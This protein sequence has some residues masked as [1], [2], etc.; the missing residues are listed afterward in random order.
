MLNSSIRAKYFLASIS[1]IFFSQFAFGQNCQI[2]VDWN[3]APPLPPGGSY[4]AG[5]VITI[6]AEI[7]DYTSG[8]ANWI[9]G[10]TINLSDAWD[11]SSITNLDLP[12]SCSGNGGE[13]LYFETLTCGG[14]VIDDPGFYYDSGVSG[15]FDGNPC[16]NW[17]DGAT[18]CAGWSFCLDI[19]LD[20][21]CGGPGNPFDGTDV[22]PTITVYSDSEVGSWNGATGCNFQPEDPP[23]FPVNLDCCDAEAGTP[24]AGPIN[25]CGNTPVDLFPLLVG[26][27]LGGTWT[28]PAGWSAPPPGD[29]NASFSPDTNPALSD[30]PGDY[31]YS[32]I[33]SDGCV[34]SSTI[35]FQF[36]DLG[37][38]WFD[39]KCGTDPFNLLLDSWGS[40]TVSLPPGGTWTYQDGT[41]IVNGD[42]DP[43]VN[44][45]GVYTY[46]FLDASDCPTTVDMDVTIVPS[47]TGTPDPLVASIDVCVLDDPFLPWD[48]LGG[49]PIVN[50]GTWL[51][52]DTTI[53][54]HVS[55]SK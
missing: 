27:D 43:L 24:P 25:I 52:Y 34:N 41:V 5:D 29:E 51:Y 49:V 2:E 1:L 42:I 28:G 21:D 8:G 12:E 15:P 35:T 32:V 31:T 14:L 22:A 50:T 53:P 11:I 17:G 44:T 20:A 38:Q 46:S 45:S 30:P 40:P 23:D 37:L 33:G 13:W 55:V 19:V 10:I 18:P 7:T 26:A 54:P 6:C 3:F 47:G 4:E 48:S 9:S 39:T 16:N 36:I